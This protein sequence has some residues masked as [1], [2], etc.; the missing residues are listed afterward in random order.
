MTK[1]LQAEAEGEAIGGHSVSQLTL[2]A[3]TSVL[4]CKWWSQACLF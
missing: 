3:E 1:D 2:G 4:F